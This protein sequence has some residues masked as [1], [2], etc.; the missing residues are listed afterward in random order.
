VNAD[1]PWYDS[2]IFQVIRKTV[3]DMHAAGTVSEET[4]AAFAEITRLEEPN[5]G[6]GSP[7]ALPGCDV[8]TQSSANPP[9]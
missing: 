7:A 9:L 2:P 4:L 8:F 5:N 6:H 1:T 3:A